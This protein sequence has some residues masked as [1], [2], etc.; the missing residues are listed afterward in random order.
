MNAIWTLA[1]EGFQEGLRNRWVLAAVAILATLAFSLALLGSTPIAETRAS[2][3]TVTTVSG[4]NFKRNA[5]SF[6]HAF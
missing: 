2:P 3:L 1:L 6:S 4:Y 5:R